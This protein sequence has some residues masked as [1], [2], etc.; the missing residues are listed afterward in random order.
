[1]PEYNA[2]IV[3]IHGQRKKVD[4]NGQE[5]RLQTVLIPTGGEP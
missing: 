2:W 5:I 1:M 4:Y 3:H